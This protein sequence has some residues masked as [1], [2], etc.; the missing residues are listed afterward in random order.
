QPKLKQ[1]DAILRWVETDE[2]RNIRVNML[3]KYDKP[4]PGK[5]LVETNIDY[6]SGVRDGLVAK[7]FTI[8]TAGTYQSYFPNRLLLAL[9][10]MGAVAAGV[11]FLTLVRPF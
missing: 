1:N 8:G 4:D 9:I 7:G 11:L 10:A 3:R 5:S 6:I 2:E